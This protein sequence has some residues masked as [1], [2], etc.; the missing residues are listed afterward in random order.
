MDFRHK[1]FFINVAN[2]NFSSDQSQPS[3][4]AGELFIDSPI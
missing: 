3:L 4:F 1:N 2:S